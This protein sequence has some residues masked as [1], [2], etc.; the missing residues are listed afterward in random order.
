MQKAEP[1]SRS[2]AKQVRRLRVERRWNLDEAAARLGVSRRLLVQL[3]SGRA[4]PTLATLLAVASGF[5]V[6]L[7]DLLADCAEVGVQVRADNSAAPALWSTS[8]GSHARLLV[9]SRVL[10]LWEWTLAAGEGRVCNPHRRGTQEALTVTAGALTLTVGTGKPV[11]IGAGQSALHDG[12]ERH[13]YD[14][15]TGLPAEFVLAVHEPLEVAS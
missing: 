14:N 13:A 15:H 2:V 3:E 10:E 4:N 6:A 8:A 11:V 12:D 7:A 5:D 9:G 1:N